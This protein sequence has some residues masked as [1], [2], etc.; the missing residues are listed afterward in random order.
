MEGLQRHSLFKPGQI[1]ARGLVPISGGDRFG[2]ILAAVTVV[3]HGDG[4]PRPALGTGQRLGVAVKG[5]IVRIEHHTTPYQAGKIFSRVK[6]KLAAYT[7][8]VSFDVDEEKIIESTKENY[9]GPVVIGEDLMS[10]IIDE[11]VKVKQL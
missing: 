7:H 9:S 2:S 5:G 6:P 11:S 10:F 8:I 4:S 3:I 1:A